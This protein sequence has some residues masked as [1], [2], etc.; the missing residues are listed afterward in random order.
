[1]IDR[2]DL[3]RRRSIRLRG[4]DY[5]RNGA[6][7]V[8]ICTQSRA[9]LFG[10]IVD[11]AMRL[12]GAGRMV[13][14]A[15]DALPVH[16]PGIGIDACVVMPNH[17]HGIVVIE[18]APEGWEPDVDTLSEHLITEILRNITGSLLGGAR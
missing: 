17:L 5:A 4:Y 13:Q 1:M 6:Y 12:N 8:T 2:A 3:H 18:K 15:W 11:G 7:F 14:Q 10:D 16:Y 9:C